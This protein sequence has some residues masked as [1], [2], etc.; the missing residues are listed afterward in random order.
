[1]SA[2]TLHTA[3]ST[4]TSPFQLVQLGGN[5]LPEFSPRNA[6]KSL[7]FDFYSP[8]I[9]LAILCPKILASRWS[10]GYLFSSFQ[11]SSP[12]TPPSRRHRLS[13]H[14][15]GPTF[16]SLSSLDPWHTVISTFNKACCS[17]FVSSLEPKANVIWHSELSN[18]FIILIPF[19]YPFPGVLTLVASKGGDPEVTVFTGREKHLEIFLNIFPLHKFWKWATKNELLN[20]VKQVSLTYKSSKVVNVLLCIVNSQDKERVYGWHDPDLF[21]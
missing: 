17:V 19:P 20:K 12:H 3:I 15:Q 10:H 4:L 16:S 13:S 2:E 7:C 1:M 14:K 8:Q 6:V 5:V 18:V 11:L 21:D 9:T